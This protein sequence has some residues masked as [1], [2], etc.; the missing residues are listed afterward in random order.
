MR[1]LTIS[2]LAAF[3]TV[4]TSGCGIDPITADTLDANWKEAYGWPEYDPNATT[5]IVTDPSAIA[6]EF[7]MDYY[8]ECTT[9]WEMAGTRSDCRSCDYAFSVELN[10]TDDS[11]GWGGRMSG[12]FMVNYGYAYFNYTRLGYVNVSGNTLSWDGRE[13]SPYPDYYGEYYYYDYYGGG[14]AYYGTATLLAR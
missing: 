3:A 5:T 8:G 12:T 1:A 7:S 6:G 13:D 10:V 4:A 14:L 9:T 2:V 11:C